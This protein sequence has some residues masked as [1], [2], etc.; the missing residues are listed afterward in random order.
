MEEERL[1]ELECVASIFPE[2]QLDPQN[3]YSLTI[4]LPVNPVKSINTIFT[5]SGIEDFR[6]I[7]SDSPNEQKPLAVSAPV[8]QFKLSHL[9][10]LRI[11]IIL[12]E[13]YPENAPPEVKLSMSMQWLTNIEI[14]DLRKSAQRIWSQHH[15]GNVVYDIIDSL[16]QSADNAFG[17]AQEDKTLQ[18][19]EEM[20]I[21]LLDYNITEIQKAFGRATHYCD[22]CLD[23]VKGSQCHQMFDCRDVFCIKCLQDFYQNAIRTGDVLSIRCLA[24]N[25]ALKKK[26]LLPASQ[27]QK[28][29]KTL[30]P[31]ELL[32][33]P[34][35]ENLVGRY[36]KLKHKLRLE[37]DKS[38]IYCP[39]KWCQGAAI[40]KKYRKPNEIDY[41]SDE[42]YLSEDS[43]PST[44][45]N[46]GD[47]LAI[48]ED[49]AFAFCRRCS[50]G[51]HGELIKCTPKISSGELSEEDKASLEYL[52]LHTTPCPTC[53]APSQKTHGC[54]HMV[55][56]KCNTHFC[57]LCSAWL[58][59]ENPYKH[60]NSETTGCYMRLWELEMGDGDDVG[61]EFVGGRN[62]RE[63]NMMDMRQHEAEHAQIAYPAVEVAQNIPELTMPPGPMMQTE[64]QMEAPLVLRINRI[65]V[66]A[67]PLT[68]NAELGQPQP[69][70]Q[71]RRLE[72][73]RRRGQRQDIRSNVQN[74]TGANQGGVDPL[75][76]APPLPNQADQDPAAQDEARQR[77]IQMFVGLALNDEEDQLEWDTEDE[78]DA[79]AWEIQSR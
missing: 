37:S 40:S 48:C 78:Q 18:V 23:A 60:Y 56:F 76:N 31:S 34:I 1:V 42:D 58:S 45:S 19:N 74:H 12:P 13:G 17:Y 70:Y 55:C 11:Q 38:T 68:V 51:W 77:W 30:S 29:L 22:I 2:I 73:Q 71:N 72:N 75:Q 14:N 5:S 66:P 79:A 47:L 59:P 61:I 6:G 49:C 4:D 7:N 32:Q 36:V 43:A 9:P 16:Q 52:K 35:D 69:P 41:E 67:Q 26:G 24:P 8:E 46:S 15:G 53:A 3:P 39:R 57:Y 10:S 63:N 62:V 28:R 65:P 20:R 27:K 54:N 50:Q 21:P 25:C 44:S 64:V 33:I